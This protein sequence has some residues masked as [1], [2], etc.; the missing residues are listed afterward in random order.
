MLAESSLYGVGETETNG[1]EGETGNVA[2]LVVNE[3]GTAVVIHQTEDPDGITVEHSVGQRLPLHASVGG[4]AILAHLSND[5]IAEH[6]EGDLPT[7]TDRTKTD[8]DPVATD[9]PDPWKGGKARRY[10]EEIP[11]KIQRTVRVIGNEAEL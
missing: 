4:K 2:R 3:H 9:L 5:G 1:L 11:Q 6:L 8:P 7:Y 10:A